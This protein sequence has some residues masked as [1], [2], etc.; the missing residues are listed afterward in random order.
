MLKLQNRTIEYLDK[1]SDKLLR[2]RF[3]R[4]VA[5]HKFKKRIE[6]KVAQGDGTPHS[7]SRLDEEQR[8]FR[9]RESTKK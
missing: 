3:E 9:R 7:G 2:R 8:F 4:Q 1:Q 5:I 6:R